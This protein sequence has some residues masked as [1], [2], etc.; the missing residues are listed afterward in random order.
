MLISDLRHGM[1]LRLTCEVTNP[2]GDRRV[3]HDWRKRKQ[4]KQGMRFLV[5][6]FFYS[7]ERSWLQIEPAGGGASINALTGD[8]L[9]ELIVANATPAERSLQSVLTQHGCSADAA[10]AILISTGKITF[11]D[12]DAAAGADICEYDNC[13]S[14]PGTGKSFCP[15]HKPES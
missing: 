3:I 5:R 2:E 1:V 13:F 7:P 14:V 12:L 15:K 9:A 4:L 6:E 11:D 10:L 8:A